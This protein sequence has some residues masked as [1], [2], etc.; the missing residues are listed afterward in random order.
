MN[1][2]FICNQNQNRSKTAEDIFKN[3]F[4]TK[5]AGLYNGKPVTEKQVSWADTIMVMEDI[6]RT[7]ISKRF[8]QHYMQKRILSLEIPDIYTF[9]Q[10]ELIKALKS[11][12]NKLF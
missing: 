3:K 11:K 8:P 10:P 5:S 7:E 4:D 12:V 6:Q 9:N 2:L 1:V